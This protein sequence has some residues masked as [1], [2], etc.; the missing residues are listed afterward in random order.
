[1]CPSQR[2]CTYLV[3]V[4]NSLTS[5]FTNVSPQTVSG[6]FQKSQL[7]EELNTVDAICNKLF[8]LKD[9]T[10]NGCTDRVFV[11]VNCLCVNDVHMF[12]LSILEN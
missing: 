1:M 6:D 2:D 9:T 7:L 3:Y 12:I 8:Y 11:T 4:V 5:R 10:N